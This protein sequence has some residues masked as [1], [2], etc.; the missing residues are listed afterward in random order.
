M[1]G[2][3]MVVFIDNSLKILRKIINIDNIK[4]ID[5]RLLHQVTNQLYTIVFKIDIDEF[6]VTFMVANF[7]PN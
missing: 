4:T 2:I 3:H 6:K 5:V 1:Y 7:Q